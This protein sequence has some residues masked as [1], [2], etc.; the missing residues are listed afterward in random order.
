MLRKLVREARVVVSSRD[1]EAAVRVVASGMV[2]DVAYRLWRAMDKLAVKVGA[3]QW[4][5]GGWEGYGDRTR[6]DWWVS[7]WSY[8]EICKWFLGG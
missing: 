1:F 7:L 8:W 2:T 5:V 4:V 6:E 3:G